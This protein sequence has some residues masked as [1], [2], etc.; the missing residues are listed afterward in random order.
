MKRGNNQ[1]QHF[2]TATEATTEIKHEHKKSQTRL[3]A[4]KTKEK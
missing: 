2:Q 4:E 3:V 1:Q